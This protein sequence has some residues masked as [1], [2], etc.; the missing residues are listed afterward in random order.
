MPLIGAVFYFSKSPR[1]L[2]EGLIWNKLMS[3]SILSI[4]LPILVFFLLKTIGKADSIYFKRVEQR[5]LPLLINSL[6]LLILLF[7]VFPSYQIIE[8]HYFFMAILMS[9]IAC[10]ILALVKFKV[11]LHMVGICGVFSFFIMLAIQYSINING[12]LALMSIL[13]GAV[14]SARLYLKAHTG[15][16]ILVGLCIGILPQIMVINYWF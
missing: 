15:L 13:T 6:I 8:L 12:T 1:F 5:K 4:A 7:R 10:F 9:N 16:E 2:P 14:A 3:L 11:S